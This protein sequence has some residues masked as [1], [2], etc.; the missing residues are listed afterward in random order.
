MAGGEKYCD[1][2]R[3][4]FKDRV[5]LYIYPG[6]TAREIL[7]AIPD[8]AVL[9]P[10]SL[11]RVFRKEFADTSVLKPGHYVIEASRPSVYVPR[12]LKGGWQ[13]PVDVVLSGT[14]RSKG[15]IARKISSQMMLDSATVAAALD[16][17]RLL[18]SYGFSSRDV[19]SLILPDTY[20]LYWT[21]STSPRSRGSELAASGDGW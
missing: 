4:N 1:N 2:K 21:A 13:T 17:D 9:H 11:A 12:M 19:F 7:A 15:G 6:M 20:E 10:G 8:S 5:D 16:D 3:P 18:S 14:M